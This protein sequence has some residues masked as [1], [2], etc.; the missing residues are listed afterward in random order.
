MADEHRNPRMAWWEQQGRSLGN[1]PEDKERDKSYLLAIYSALYAELRD[2]DARQQQAVTWGIT[3]L[4]G[5]GLMGSLLKEGPF[6]VQTAMLAVAVLGLLAWVLSS[7]VLALAE[8]RMSIARQ[9]DRIHE[10]MGVFD[11]GRYYPAASLF[12]PVWRGW[13]FDRQRDVNYHHSKRFA[14]VIWIVFTLDAALLIVSAWQA[15][16]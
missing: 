12:D 2:K 1:P 3:I 11:A 4:A 14:V 15:A 7:I 16:G 6:A 13:G 10:L 9:L 5:G 8:D